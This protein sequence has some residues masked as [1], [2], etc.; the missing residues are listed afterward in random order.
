M[1]G[2][3]G[4]GGRRRHARRQPEPDPGRSV[5]SER[6][7]RKL[8]PASSRGARPSRGSRASHWPGHRHCGHPALGPGR[9]PARSGPA[10]SLAGQPGLLGRLRV[11]GTRRESGAM[12]VVTRVWGHESCDRVT[13]HWHW[14]LG[15]LR[16]IDGP[17]S[18]CPRI[19]RSC[20]MC[21]NTA[22]QTLKFSSNSE[23]VPRTLNGRRGR[24]LCT[25]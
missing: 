17:V 19:D 22:F 14:Q 7:T 6:S 5:A 24:R 15:C 21:H 8:H 13:R 23:L 4:P 10:R 18:S 11:G 20:G 16:G 25:R 2:T 1:E 3:S 9:A 12:R